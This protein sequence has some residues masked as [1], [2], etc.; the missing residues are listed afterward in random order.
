MLLASTSTWGNADIN[1]VELEKRHT[2][3][4]NIVSAAT[5]AE[6]KYKGKIENI[7]RFIQSDQFNGKINHYAGSV[8]RSLNMPESENDTA[9]LGNMGPRLI[10][11]VSASVPLTTLRN[12]AHDLNRIGGVMVFK[13]PVEDATKLKP[14]MNLMRKIMAVEPGCLQRGCE[15]LPLN[16]AVDPARFRRYGV[17]EVPAAVIETNVSFEPNCNGERPYEKQSEIVYGDASI[18]T[19]LQHLRKGNAKSTAVALLKKLEGK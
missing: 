11:F 1:V 7:E 3:N 2:L 17:S 9:L 12:Y 18:E 19:M 6:N 14:M 4:P 8:K 13:A 5:S 15:M 16:V 10:L